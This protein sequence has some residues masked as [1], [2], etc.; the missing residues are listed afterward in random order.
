MKS[1]FYNPFKR[2]I[3]IIGSIVGIVLFS[4]ILISVFFLIKFFQGGKVIF[5]QKRPGKGERIF[6]MYKFCSMKEIRD[7]NNKL[8]PDTQRLTKIGSFLRKTSIDEL[9]ELFNVLKGDMSLVGPR[10]LLVSY[11][12][13]YNDYQKKRH[14]IRPGITGWAQINGRNSISW[15]EKFNLDIWYVENY[16]FILDMK[17][18]FS[19][20]KKVLA[21]DNVNQNKKNTM[22]E[23]YGNDK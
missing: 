10:P 15:E 18:I 22:S 8:L 13:R 1:N 23:F 21:H 6:K 19:T 16:S 4:P 11:L 2:L 17:I 5:I 12:E 20:I 9:P 7:K 3:D 14:D